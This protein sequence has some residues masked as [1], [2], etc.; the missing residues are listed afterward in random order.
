MIRGPPGG[1]E[2]EQRPAEPSPPGCG[3]PRVRKTQGVD[4]GS[5]VL[6]LMFVVCSI[7]WFGGMVLLC[8]IDAL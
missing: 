8:L 5:Q 1:G 4:V 3:V 6:G 2:A 7:V